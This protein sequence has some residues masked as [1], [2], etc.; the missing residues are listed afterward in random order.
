MIGIATIS[1]DSNMLDSSSTVWNISDVWVHPD[2]RRHGIATQLVSKC[3]L[4][5]KKRGA[6]EIRLQVY[7]TNQGASM[8]YGQLGYRTIVRTM[9][10][11]LT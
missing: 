9:R 5:A 8:M 2:F 1:L 10:R 7:S 6:T 3:E 4:I 11:K